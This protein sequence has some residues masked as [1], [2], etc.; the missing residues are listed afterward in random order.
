MARTLTGHSHIPEKMRMKK[1]KRTYKLKA[2]T[3]AKIIHG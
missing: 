1:D 3:I 2:E